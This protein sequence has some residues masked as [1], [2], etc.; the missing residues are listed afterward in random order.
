[1]QVLV[2]LGDAADGLALFVDR[3]IDEEAIAAGNILHKRD[4][5]AG[6]GLARVAGQAER[7]QPGRLRGYVVSDDGLVAGPRPDEVDREVFRA[8]RLSPFAPGGPSR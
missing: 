1:M 8:V 7:F 6:Y 5:P 2:A 3:Q 4:S